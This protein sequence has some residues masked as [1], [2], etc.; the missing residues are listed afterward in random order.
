MIEVY[1]IPVLFSRS[2]RKVVS[3]DPV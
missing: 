3:G 2:A 1:R